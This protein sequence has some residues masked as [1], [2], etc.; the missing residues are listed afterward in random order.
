[1]KQNTNKSFRNMKQTSGNV[2]CCTKC[3]TSKKKQEKLLEGVRD[4]INEID[5]L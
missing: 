4:T 1:M 3:T 2:K 5:I